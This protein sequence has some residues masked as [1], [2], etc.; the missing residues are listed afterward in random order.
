LDAEGKL[1][2]DAA[3][4]FMKTKPQEELYD[5][6]NDPSEFNNLAKDPNYSERVN[7]LKTRLKTKR[8]AAGY[9]AKR[10]K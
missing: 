5:L 3:Y 9:D 10:Y 1:E 2:G 4:I 6:K 7:Q 8:K